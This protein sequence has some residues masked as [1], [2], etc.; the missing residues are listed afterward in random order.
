M[1][2]M[3][4]NLSVMIRRDDMSDC[5]KYLFLRSSDFDPRHPLLVGGSFK[6]QHNPAIKNALYLQGVFGAVV[7]AGSGQPPNL[8]EQWFSQVIKDPEYIEDQEVVNG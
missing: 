7:D 5:N 2:W 8:S 6:K 3:G 1:K 4:I